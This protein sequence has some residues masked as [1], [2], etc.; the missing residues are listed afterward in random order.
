MDNQSNDDAVFVWEPGVGVELNVTK[1]FRIN[2]G[3][4]CRFVSGIN[5]DNKSDGF[6]NKDFSGLNGSVTFKFGRF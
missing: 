3:A 5:A 6:E 1:F 2:F 4:S